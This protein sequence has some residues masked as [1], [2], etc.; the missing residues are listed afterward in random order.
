[1]KISFELEN[2]TEGNISATKDDCGDITLQ[3]FSWDEGLDKFT[4]NTIRMDR[5]HFAQLVKYLLD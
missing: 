2:L 1:M 5:E 4:N 3:Q